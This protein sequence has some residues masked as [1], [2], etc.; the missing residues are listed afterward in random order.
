MLRSTAGWP[1]ALAA[2][3]SLLAAR[4]GAAAELQDRGAAFQATYVWQ[5]K[6][7]FAAAYSGPNSLAS[8]R[9]RSYSLS[10]TA[11]LGLRP[12]TGGELYVDPEVVQGQPLSNLQGLGGL[13]N[14]E[15]QKTSGPNP[16]PYVARAFLRQTWELGGEREDVEAAPNQL[17]GSVATQRLVL[18]AGKVA[19]TDLFDRNEVAADP[20][21]RFLNW[22]FLT[23]GAYD[24]AADARGYTWGAAVEWIH[25]GWALR[26]GRFL[27]P[28]Q[29]NGLSLDWGA[30][31]HF[32]DQAELEHGHSLRGRPGTLRLLVFRNR[33]RMARYTDA[34]ALGASAGTTPDLDAV[35]FGEQGKRGAGVALE[36]Q[37]SANASVFARAARADGRTEPYSF[38]EIDSSLSAGAVLKGAAWGRGKDTAGLAV[39]RNGLSAP[40]RQYLA[41]GGLGFFIGEGRLTYRPEAIAEA[42]YGIAAS[43]H[44]FVTLDWQHIVHPAY[45]ADRGPVNVGSLRVHLEF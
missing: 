20:R 23:H 28:D 10:A 36:Q 30:A 19:I 25:G 43:K 38:A 16:T 35:R 39:A 27:V 41:A 18:T 34:L 7:A 2:A 24:Y 17:A 32:G 21:T 8:Q 22:S 12:W 14:G 31:R 4:P 6:P 45:N 1:F 42:Y 29:P 40:H 44:A 11:F 26:A 3:V 15:N 13:T 33:A 5:G 37:V 9:E